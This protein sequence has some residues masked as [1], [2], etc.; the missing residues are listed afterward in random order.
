MKH[1]LSYKML[2]LFALIVTCVVAGVY[3]Y[4]YKTVQISIKKSVEAKQAVFLAEKNKGN[5][6]EYL[7][8]F[9]KIEG[10]WN[11]LQ[12]Y[13]VST[14]KIVEFIENV[15]NFRN[16]TGATTTLSGLDADKLD[17]SK[18]GSTG[19]LRA[20]VNAEGSWSMVMKTL[21][22]AEALPY[23]MSM[24]DLRLTK[25]NSAANGSGAAGSSHWEIG[26]DI[27]VGLIV[28]LAPAAT[29]IQ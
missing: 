7:L 13:F 17:P 29:V 9:A 3:L 12:S 28:P 11:K 4:M 16:V 18:P 19:V 14:E 8:T 25:I 20:R 24:K 27:S 2:L 15:E 5:E 1:S 6:Q 23:K 21:E 26:F 10:D 22:L